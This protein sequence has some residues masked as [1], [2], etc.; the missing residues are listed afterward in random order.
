LPV[1]EARWAAYRLAVSSR[2]IPFPGMLLVWRLLPSCLPLK[3]G[4]S[5]LDRGVLG[6]Y[7]RLLR[8]HGF[9]GARSPAQAW[10]EPD[11]HL[12]ASLDGSLQELVDAGRIDR[13]GALTIAGRSLGVPSKLRLAAPSATEVFSIW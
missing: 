9:P 8:N 3:N 11:V 7:R 10:P 5:R 13:C 4:R 1:S 12:E 6:G 2:K